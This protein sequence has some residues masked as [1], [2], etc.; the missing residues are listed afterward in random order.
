MVPASRPHNGPPCGMHGMRAAPPAKRASHPMLPDATTRYALGCCCLAYTRRRRASRTG[1]VTTSTHMSP[2]PDPGATVNKAFSGLASSGNR[3]R[4]RP[5]VSR[6]LY[7]TELWPIA[8]NVGIEPTTSGLHPCSTTKLDHLVFAASCAAA[9]ASPI[10][11]RSAPGRTHEP[12][13]LT[14]RSA[15]ECCCARGTVPRSSML[16]HR[17][18]LTMDEVKW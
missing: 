11:R 12:H 13:P 1:G 5:I 17:A 16:T 3:T 8:V 10:C 2:K 4:D 7:P 14:T 6:L 9:Y 18:T 15:N